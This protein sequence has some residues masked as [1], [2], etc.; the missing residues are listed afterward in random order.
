MEP[1]AEPQAPQKLFTVTTRSRLRGPWFFPHMMLASLRIRRQ[2][3]RTGNVVRWASIVAGPSEFWTITVWRSRHDMQEFMRSCA[4]DE[5]M[6][7]LSKWLASFWL[8]R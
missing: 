1:V 3:A 5:F 8:M 7:L 6:W 4:Y 2:L